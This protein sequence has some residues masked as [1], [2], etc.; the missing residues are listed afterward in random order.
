[1]IF[2]LHAH[3]QY[4]FNNITDDAVNNINIDQWFND[5]TE[6]ENL[7]RYYKHLDIIK[8]QD[9][10]EQKFQ[11][12]GLRTYREE[13][14][15]Y[16]IKN[17]NIIA[18]IPGEVNPEIIYIIGAH[19]DSISEQ[20][21]IK[22]PGAEDNASGTAGLFAIARAL[23]LHPP[24]FTLRFVAFA[25]EEL[26]LFGSKRHVH[27]IVEEDYAHNVRG[28]LIMDM[29]AFS[30]DDDLDILLETSEDFK[31]LTELVQA[32]AQKYS[33]ARIT[34]TFNYWGSDHV[35]FINKNINT[36]LI[37]ENDYQ[38]YTHY[39]RSTDISANLNKNMAHQILKSIV[40]S[41]G[42]WVYN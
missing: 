4:I 40:G 38:E 7:N 29:I 42:F 21:L 23:M 24:K 26:G 28:V 19:Y 17:Y 8:A 22:A 6:L 10:I 3:A 37:I 12:I 5:V 9:L 1:M 25:G 41:V 13:V 27:T 39:H 2:S 34:T 18:E 35:P 20:P 36:L 30:Q 33:E 11:E 14:D 16:N 15:I 31:D 32:A